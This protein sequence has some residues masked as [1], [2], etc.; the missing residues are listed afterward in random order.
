[1]DGVVA[2]IRTP[3]R[4]LTAEPP[5]HASELE[6]QLT[7]LCRQWVRVPLPIFALCLYIS[8]L[9]W[10]LV[11]PAL[12]VGW[13]VATVV[14]LS[15]RAWFV[16]RLRDDGR[17][18]RQTS[19]W[20]RLLVAFAAVNGV[21]GGAAAPLFLGSLP[22][23]TQAMLVMVMCCWGAGAIATN[24]AYP[25]AYLAFTLPLFAQ[26]AIGWLLF[27]E[28]DAVYVVLLL[29]ALFGML[30][31]FVR[32]GGRMLVQSIRLRH[33]YEQTLAQKEALIELLRSAADEASDARSKAEQANRSK[34]QFLASASHDLRQPLHSLSL[35]TGAMYEVAQ[36][37]YLREVAQQMDRSVQSLDRLFGALLD[38]S[39]LDAG[40]VVIEPQDFDLAEMFDRLS[41]EHRAKAR[42]KGLAFHVECGSIWICADPILLERIIRNLLENAI[43][44]TNAGSI[45]IQAQSTGR[46]LA[47]TVRD[48][49]I[50]VPQ[51]EQVRIFEEFFQLHN[52]GRDRTHGL[53]LGLSIV[54][55]LVDMLG[56][57]LHLESR[58]GYGSSFTVALPEALVE[59]MTPVS[60]AKAPA[61]DPAE[62]AALRTST[63]LV[64]EDDGE[65]RT[66]MALLLRRWGCEPVIA[67]SLEDALALLKNR[68]LVPRM[69][70]S[71]LRL[72]G[73]AS[74]VEAIADLRARFGTLPAAIIT[75]EISGER[76]DALQASGLP[77]LQKPL[78]ARTLGQL[79]CRLARQSPLRAA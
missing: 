49:G 52:A 54:R 25:P 76:I 55:R 27:G 50:G 68:A 32:D 19:R 24:G 28:R 39:K 72:A 33:A 3:L 44:F 75:G 71:D 64:L 7:L 63:V 22:L 42:E 67:P 10:G 14:P 74:G 34:S 40:A 59:R 31:I 37:P 17:L 26:V 9:V 1:M 6:E 45:T 69:I 79:L 58:P 61:E 4:G 18:A 20:A 56:Y 51:S 48:T 53:G 21:L 60:G 43:R 77:V 41:V 47:L 15:V 29:A 23:E 66:A 30:V 13:V 46:D 12:V 73:G 35:L 62:M 70:L 8:H 38:L 11:P 78:Q 16:M 5:T 57:R 65:V 2:S 36:D